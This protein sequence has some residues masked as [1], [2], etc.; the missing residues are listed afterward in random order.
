MFYKGKHSETKQRFTIKKFK[1]GAASVLIGTLFFTGQTL[2]KAD[3]TAAS[4]VS[5]GEAVVV[6]TATQPDSSTDVI[7]SEITPSDTE[8]S[9]DNAPINESVNLENSDKETLVEKDSGSISEE[10]PPVHKEERVEE[11][12]RT[13]P[14]FIPNN[15]VPDLSNTATAK[16]ANEGQPIPTDGKFRADTTARAIPDQLEN[17]TP[18]VIENVNAITDAEAESIRRAIVNANPSLNYSNPNI[19]FNDEITIQQRGGTG[20]PVGSTTVIYRNP[21]T[22]DELRRFTLSPSDVT[23]TP[24]QAI[25]KDRLATTINWFDL[26]KAEITYPPGMQKKM[27]SQNVRNGDPKQYEALQVG[28]TFKIPT[29][30]DGYEITATVT[31]LEAKPVATDPNKQSDGTNPNAVRKYKSDLK[32][33]NIQE[34]DFGKAAEV[35]LSPQSNWSHLKRAGISTGEGLTNFS[36]NLNHGNVGVSFAVTATYKGKPVSVALIAADGEEGSM[37]E[38][39]QFI[40]DGTPWREF[41]NISSNTNSNGK[42]TIPRSRP[43]TVNDLARD[44]GNGSL[45]FRGAQLNAEE[46]VVTDADGRPAIYGKDAAGN[47]AFGPAI[48]G[49]S[50]GY[51]NRLGSVPIGISEDVSNFSI[52]INSFGAQSAMIGFVVY[53]SGDAPESYGTAKHLLGPFSTISDTGV[54]TIH[55]QPY[56]GN[57]PGDP[58]YQSTSGKDA[59]GAWS[60]DDVVYT[61]AYSEQKLNQGDKITLADGRTGTYSVNKTGNGILTFDNGSTLALRNSE[62]ITIAKPDGKKV[63]GVFNQVNKAI[64][65]GALPDEGERQLLDETVTTKYTVK[66]SSDTEYTLKGIEAHLGENND[67]AFVRGW[68]DFNGDGV[69]NEN[70]SSELLEIRKDG[71]VDLVFK[72]TPQLLN[73][74]LDT[75]GVRVR[76]ALDGNEIL[77]P[78]ST[79]NSGEV[80]DFKTSIEHLP[81]GTKK[82]TSGIQGEKQSTSLEFVAYGKKSP[83]FAA[84]NNINENIPAKIVLTSDMVASEKAT[85]T[86]NV[87]V[88]DLAGTTVYN[89]PEVVV[90]DAQG[91]ELG[92][93][94][95]VTNPKTNAVEYYLTTYDEY[96]SQ[97]NKVGTYSVK[98]FSGTN[99][100]NSAVEVEFTPELGY[101][102]RAKGVAVRAWDDNRNGTGWT[103]TNATIEES[104][105]QVQRGLLAPKDAVRTNTNSR[106]VD[107]VNGT[108][109]MDSVYIPTVIDI[110]PIGD[111]VTTTDKQGKT[112]SVTVT[113]PTKGTVYTEN[114]NEILEKP[115][116]DIV[117]PDS[118]ATFLTD[119]IQVGA[120][121]G[122]ATHVDPN[123]GAVTTVDKS[124]A[125][126][127]ENRIVIT[128]EGTYTIDP[129]TKQV[130]FTPDPNFVGKATGVTVKQADVDYTTPVAGERA[131]AKYGTDYATNKYTPIV[132]PKTEAAITRNIKYVYANDNDAP[133]DLATYKDNESLPD[134]KAITTSQTLNFTRTYTFNQDGTVTLGNWTPVDN[135]TFDKVVSPELEGYTAEVVPTTQKDAETSNVKALAPEPQSIRLDDS[136]NI[137][138][139]VVYKKNPVTVTEEREEVKRT[140]NYKYEDG[141]PVLENGN[142]KVIEETLVYTRTK[143]VDDVTGKTTY[144]DWATTDNEFDLVETAEI[145]GYTPNEAFVPK[146]PKVIATAEDTVVDVVYK[147]DDQLA[148][149]KFINKN[150]NETIDVIID[151]GKTNDPFG[152]K[153]DVDRRLTELKKQGYIIETPDTDNDYPNGDARKFDTDKAVDQEYTIKLVESVVPAPETPP[154]PGKP[155]NPDDPNSPVWP[156]TVADLL[157]SKDINR[158]V[159]YVKEE[160]GKEVASGINDAVDKVTFERKAKVN[161]V[162]GEIIYDDWLPKNGDVTFDSIKTPILQGYVADKSSVPAV[163]NTVMSSDLVEKVIYKPIGKY[164]P[165]V[166]DGF[167]EPELPPYKNDP[168]D[169]TA[170]TPPETLIPYISGTTPVGPDGPLKPKN[171][172]DPSEGYIPPTPIAGDVDTPIVYLENGVQVASV[173]YVVEKTDKVLDTDTVTGKA[174]EPIVFDTVASIKELNKRGYELV[175][176]GYATAKASEK[177]FDDDSDS[178]QIFTVTVRPKSTTVTPNEPKVPGT[179]INPDNP[180]GPRWPDGVQ[181]SALKRTI[182]REVSYVTNKDGQEVPVAAVAT[183]S[184]V[185]TRTATVNEVTGEVT[186]SPWVAT[187]EDTTFEAIKSPVVTGYLADKATVPIVS[188]LTTDSYENSDYILKEKVVYTPIG[189]FVPKVPEGETPIPPIPYPN[190][191]DD[192]TKP[193]TPTT[194]IPHIPGTTPQ[195]PD[196]QPLTPVDPKDLSKGY[197]P[198]AID[199]N[200][201]GKDTDITYVKDT[202]KATI[203]FVDPKGEAIPGTTPIEETGKSGEPISTVELDKQ[204]AELKKK[205]YVVKENPLKD[206]VN[207]DKDKTTDQTFTVVLE[208]PKVDIPVGPQDPNKPVGPDNPIV[209][210]NPDG[211]PIKPG[212]PINPNNPDGPKWT[213]EKL[214][215]IKKNTVDTV[216]RT[217]DYVKA[218]GTKASDSVV[219]NATFSRPF[220]IDGVTLEVT[221]GAWTPATADLD[222]VKTPVVTGYLA[223]KKEVAKTTVEPGAEDITETVTYR[224]IGS[225]VPKDPEGN[226]IGDP[227]PYP[228]DPKDPTKPGTPTTPIPHIPGTTPQGPDGQPLTPVDPK[229]PSKGYNPPAIDPNNPN[230]DI[231]YVKDTQKAT[232]TFV[233]P[234]GEGIPGTTPIE[235]TGKSGEPISTV[236]LDKQLAELK[237]KGYVVKEN[238]LKDGANFDKDKTTDQTFTVVLEAPKVDIP[239]GPQDP[240]KPVGPDNPIV[241]LNPDGTPIK[242]GDPINPNN[243]DGPK[244]TDEKLNEI[245]KNTVDT[246]T[247]T[248]DYVKADGTKASDSVVQNATFSRPFTIDGV[249]LEVTY[250]AWTPA[251]ADLDAVKTPVVT[252]YLADKKEV[253]KTTVAPGAEDIT[254]TVT[255]RPIGSFVPK[256]PEGNPIGNPIPYPNDPKDP[257]KPGTP[258]TPIPHIPGT[259]PQGPDGQPLTPVD[260]K[261]PSK[262]YNPPAIDPNNP[263]TDITYVKD[264]QK[265]TITFVDP[266]G[267]AIP[268]T[269]PIEETGK[270]GEP[271]S[272]VELDKQL[273][274][275]KKKGYVVK[276]NPLKDGANFDTDKAKDQDFTVVLEAPK[277]D[278]PVGPQ[279]PNKPV[280]P[281]NPI[282]PLNPDGKPIKPGDPINPNNPDGPKWTDEKLNEI[283][284][285]TVD[286]VTRT[287][288]YVKAD[289][290]KASDSVVQNAT[291][292]RPF[293]IDG[294]TLEVTYGAWT[295]ATADLDA[296]KT[297]VVT[298]YLADKK[299]VAKTT[300][301]PGAEDITETVTYRP[302][303]SFV[304]KDP[305]GNPIGD[306]IPYPNDPKDPTKPGTP[307]TPIPHIPGTTPQGPDGQPLTPV[308]PKD[309]SKGYIPPAIDPN[310]PGKDID[311]VYIPKTIVPGKE[312]QPEVPERS[313]DSNEGNTPNN[314]TDNHS[315]NPS[316]VSSEQAKMGSDSTTAKMTE[317]PKTGDAGSIATAAFGL[318]TILA[319]LGLVKP[320]RKKD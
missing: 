111:G 172:L 221:Y 246:V 157:T 14:R 85:S 98:G 46:W 240:N 248:I 59:S 69:F 289:G 45:D 106:L 137:D 78:T 213:D 317:L 129:T 65:I 138:V 215:E 238:P 50:S 212:D 277:V 207:F 19:R 75:V 41:T 118:P 257:T 87:N 48:T 245:K 74:S 120:S 97:G 139:Y 308:D 154:V 83:E 151:K 149:V 189:S 140:I 10:T 282:V 288:D 304:P 165:K 174:G 185:F 263:N 315:G 195:G 67:K 203:T 43:Q 71:T 80:E 146:S 262:G 51:A 128:G 275:L 231:T 269:T 273:A 178:P 76:I 191:S 255:Y 184:V 297:P 241:P 225:F 243:P 18:T 206:G 290:T 92:T 250:G 318:G 307:T 6:E 232:I 113:L 216:T 294:V 190:H 281:D 136:D 82:E 201:P 134:S 63:I 252:G 101:V 259:T 222:A 23:T 310:N 293:T 8:E 68:V 53:D 258:T 197:N 90:L 9:I 249:T 57:T 177:V 316:E 30:I 279:D 155:I 237:K 214:N 160:G 303:G 266:K 79:A 40:S 91:H 217:I 159:V 156:P 280:G 175:T 256:D 230:T 158:R 5:E 210:L 31:K 141:S 234:K 103:A 105:K 25:N 37:S 20:T 169:P 104:L 265:A 162:T 204:L 233:D 39:V 254:E 186:Y 94:V 302:I 244:W 285:N 300:V 170:V 144:T 73:T 64:A 227:I 88:T 220:T 267:E 70:E 247:R 127:S 1:I 312:L 147:K 123:T 100:G 112:Q 264:T 276:E 145:P 187:D 125:E 229:D 205:G 218:D 209:P 167:K 119:G 196:G 32:P 161:I 296:V 22:G 268:G 2:V 198:P 107:D 171:P 11:K 89:G 235:E 179:P 130:T 126:V 200:N 117:N 176:D 33:G 199:P 271:I 131:T 133:A 143:T 164:V 47:N 299:E 7:S 192:P 61:E 110:K 26:S 13:T 56:L 228:N 29:K 81:R 52:Y 219:Q 284:K 86:A 319:S 260:P 182:K 121:A 27:V 84:W 236:E 132:T 311:I 305:E 58:D 320:R 66:K 93:A 168:N 55:T 287:I 77:T 21:E 188:G 142:P 211:K 183:D 202:Q 116:K 124:Y 153:D 99:V 309:P 28:M 313:G 224:P 15:T 3:V 44:Y 148:V 261:D 42:V 109:S 38:V 49:F 301:E 193:G 295:P 17:P 36:S 95:K 306:P 286:T 272:T 278:I 115:T 60:L 150:T 24:T 163:E 194:P 251:T 291:F 239:V 96:D 181:E 283:K 4:S 62:E 223:D 108:T 298:G 12:P 122:Q 114:G 34:A 72:N 54:A 226:T 35:I 16:P 208:A 292:S 253:A 173:N 242:P 270:S 135:A 274:E 152:K 166:P 102:G 180:E 314:A